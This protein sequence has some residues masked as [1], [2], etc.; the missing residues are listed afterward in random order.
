MN[1]KL[2]DGGEDNLKK[3]NLEDWIQDNYAPE[4]LSRFNELKKESPEKNAIVL[5]ELAL[6]EVY[7]DELEEE[8]ENANMCFNSDDREW[9]L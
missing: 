2:D 7:S 3:I 4:V 1:F 9:S 8:E 6:A 5:F